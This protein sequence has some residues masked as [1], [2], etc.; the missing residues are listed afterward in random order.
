MSNCMEFPKDYVDFINDYSFTD[1]EEVYTN[2]GLLIP[3]YRVEQ[4]IRHYFDED[5]GHPNKV[6]FIDNCE[7]RLAVG[8]GLLLYPG[9]SFSAEHII[10]TAI[11]H[12]GQV[13]SYDLAPTLTGIDYIE[14]NGV[15]FIKENS[16]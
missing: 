11:R 8:K 14:V 13:M 4:M 10:M 9:I 7:N 2:G 15:K 6:N 16:K 1:K 5:F 3:V 12:D